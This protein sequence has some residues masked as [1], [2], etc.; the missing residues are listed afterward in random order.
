MK[1]AIYDNDDNKWEFILLEN[2]KRYYIDNIE[3]DI[4]I[5]W[6]D[7][8]NWVISETEKSIKNSIKL[9][10]QYINKEFNN[11]IS[12]ITTWYTQ[13]EIDTFKTKEE[14]AKIVLEW[15]TSEFLE[16]LLIEWETIEELA[17]KIMKN[18]EEYKTAFAKAEQIKRQALKD[19]DYET[20]C[21]QKLEI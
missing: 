20:L 1:I 18:A 21:K 10:K 13:A 11:S 5:R 15:W 14:E 17:E 12:K 8:I 7:I 2:K 9:S 16:K 6:W 4:I 3:K 19:L